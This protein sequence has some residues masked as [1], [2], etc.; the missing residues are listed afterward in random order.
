[1]KYTEEEARKQVSEFLYNYTLE[2][3]KDEKE[4]AVYRTYR[5]LLHR[6]KLGPESF[7]TVCKKIGLIRVVHYI[8]PEATSIISDGEKRYKIEED[9]VQ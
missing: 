5:S 2:N 8:K 4:M 9:E 1:M 3:F 7:D 6:N